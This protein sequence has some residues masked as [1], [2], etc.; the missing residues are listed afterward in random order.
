MN[1]N[2]NITEEDVFYLSGVDRDLNSRK[3][4]IKRILS[5]STMRKLPKSVD[6]YN[7]DY[8]EKYLESSEIKDSIAEKY[9][10]ENLRN[11]YDITWQID[12]STAQ[13]SI[14]KSAPSQK[15][16][17][18]YPVDDKTISSLRLLNIDVEAMELLIAE[19]ITEN[20]DTTS[21]LFI[22]YQR[23]Y[24][25]KL[26][27]LNK[28][29]ENIANRFELPYGTQWRIDFQSKEMRVF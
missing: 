23:D 21:D 26:E 6:M 7:K 22:E 13:L 3:N 10:P 14:I 29:K 24:S 28:L 16:K 9:I 4:V 27:E 17:S 15:V 8:I 19:Y 2:Y 20:L 5:S 11:S 18:V 1:K 25:D 12:Y